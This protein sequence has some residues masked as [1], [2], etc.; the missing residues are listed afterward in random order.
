MSLFD[1][2]PSSHSPFMALLTACNFSRFLAPSSPN[3]LP[4]T[5]RASAF[6]ASIVPT[7]FLPL[8]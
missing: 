2:P 3:A 1:E 4:S 5:S 6:T 7:G 8:R